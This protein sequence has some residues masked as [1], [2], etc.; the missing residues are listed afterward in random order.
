M[1]RG[2]NVNGERRDSGESRVSGPVSV[3]AADE[4]V[5]GRRLNTPW[6]YCDSWMPRNGRNMAVSQHP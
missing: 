4:R 5:F 6:G 2:V 1:G 3:P